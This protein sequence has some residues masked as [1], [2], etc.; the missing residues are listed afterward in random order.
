LGVESLEFRVGATC[1]RRVSDAAKVLVVLNA[2][3]AEGK[4]RT[5]RA[6][7]RK[8]NINWKV[9]WKPFLIQRWVVRQS[10]ASSLFL[11]VLCG[12]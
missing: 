8:K 11:C 6:T 12:S 7:T 2:E 3:D 10:S 9:V 4:E 1:P 5:Q